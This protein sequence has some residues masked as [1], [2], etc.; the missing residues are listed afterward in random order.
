MLH[1]KSRIAGSPTV[2]AARR[3]AFRPADSRARVV[4]RLP[5]QRPANDNHGLP[6]ILRLR[7]PVGTLIVATAIVTAALALLY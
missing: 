4:R 3:K 6:G 1:Q 2:Q 5:A 7:R